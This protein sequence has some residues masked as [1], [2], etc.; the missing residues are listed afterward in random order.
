MLA[1]AVK[2]PCVYA[3]SGGGW[4][5]PTAWSTFWRWKTT[6]VRAREIRRHL[7]T[8]P[9]RDPPL[10]ITTPI[11][12]ANAE[13]H[14][15][16]LYSTVLAD[17]LQRWYRLKGHTTVFS[18]GTDEHGQK[19][20]EAAERHKMEAGP[21][22]DM[23]SEKFKVLFNSA[24]IAYTDYIRTTEPRHKKAVHFLWKLLLDRGYIYR[25]YHEGWYAVS[26]ETFYPASQIEEVAGPDGKMQ[27]ISKES[28]QRVIWMKEE[29]YK[30]RLSMLREPLIAWLQSNPDVIIPK[31]KYNEILS[32]LLTRADEQLA[33]L[34]VS[35]LRSRVQWGIMVPGD[36]DH[37]IYVWLD[38]LANYLTVLG[39]PWT[40]PEASDLQNAWPAQCHVVGKDILKFHA[41]YWPAFLMAA[42]L[43]PPRRIVAHAHWL[44]GNQKM[45]KSRGNVVDPTKLL[46]MYGV[47][48]VRYFLMRDGG[49]T[50]DA[51][52]ADSMIHMRYK[53][54]LAGQLGNLA[55]RCSAP[56]I[57]P[58]MTIPSEPGVITNAE[59][60]LDGKL[61][62][63]PAVV[64]S[65]FENVEFGRGLESVFE[66]VSEANKYWDACKPWILVKSSEPDAR[67]RLRTIL[68]YAFE[69]VR[70]AGLL[71]QPVLPQ[72]MDQML[73]DIAV[74]KDQRMWQN[75]VLGHRWR[76]GGDRL[77]RHVPLPEKRKPLFPKLN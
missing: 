11:F 3:L 6:T 75:A 14:I 76:D 55:M 77:R 65:R 74:E 41:I 53:K 13:P 19:I 49:I 39:Y 17:T 71:L 73:D 34:S 12:Y 67:A 5:R 57:N 60:V 1:S 23:V 61:R 22:C 21:F 69:T 54:D 36:D 18:T 44:M 37:V 31:T 56:R 48:P 63:L 58:E 59:A 62:A 30:F 46:S 42:G 16:H 43:A 51:E 26:D 38:A 24:N 29:N 28:G 40:C 8:T 25:G 47:D 33:D 64:Q 52:F 32:A 45:S 72:K 15:G 27:T 4:S 9:C 68:Y 2:A 35:R 10:F 66:C 50:N 70:M 7:T 20:Q